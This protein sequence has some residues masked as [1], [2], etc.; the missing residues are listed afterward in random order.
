LAIRK[1]R[2]AT[3]LTQGEVADMLHWSI[4]KVNRI[5]TGENTISSTDLEALLLLLGVEDE[6][7]IELMRADARAAR[8]RGS[9]WWDAPRF[10]DHLRPTTVQMLQFESEASAIR[11]FHYAVFPA[12]LQTREYAEAVIR[13][14]SGDFTADSHG[15]V[16]DARMLRKEK[17]RSRPDK[18]QYLAILDE[19][20]LHRVVG[21]DAIMV[22]Q[23]KSVA[24]AARAPNIL[25]RL[26]PKEASAHILIGS[27]VLFDFDQESAV[28]YREFSLT[29]EVL[30]SEDLVA[31]HRLRFAQMWELCLSEEATIGAIEA[32]Y[33]AV[34]ARLLRLGGRNEQLKEEGRD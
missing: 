28:L 6:G 7:L 27:F 12:L 29:D 26:L 34:R 9:G 15:A 4:S 2:E 3:T 13:A 22:E 5:E 16:A 11:V 23:L 14:L 10:R 19:L 24:E 32:Q 17:F 25:V 1:A 20:L 8:K 21:D 30:H 31:R 18:P 33:A